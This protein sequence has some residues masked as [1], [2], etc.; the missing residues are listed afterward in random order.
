MIVHTPMCQERKRLTDELG[1][2][3]KWIMSIHNKELEAVIRGETVEKGDELARAT[4]LRDE[5]KLLLAA[6]RREHGC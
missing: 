2:A 6:H 1:D 3:L 4:A 5:F